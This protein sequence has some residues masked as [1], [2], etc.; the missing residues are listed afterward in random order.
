MSNTEAS[1]NRTDALVERLFMATIDTMEE[2]ASIHVGGRLGFYRAL[3]EDGPATPAELASRTAT[4]ERY[5]REW[6]EQQAVAGFLA[7]ENTEAEAGERRYSLPPEHRPVFVDELDLH[8]LVGFAQ[9][10]IGMLRPIDALLDAYRSGGGVPYEAY[11]PDLVAGIAA[12]N[13]PQFHNLLAGWFGEIQEVDARLRVE[14]AARV[15]DVGCGVGWSSIAIAHAYPNAIVDAIDIDTESV[16]AARSNVAAAGLTERVHP[17]THDASRSDLGG[18]YDLITVFEALHDMNHPVD[19]LR[20]FRA[21][22]TDG[23]CVVIADERVAD[24]FTAPGDEIER[25][26]YGFSILHC[27]PVANLDED[28]AATGTVI[29]SDT[30]RA[31]ATE[32]GFGRVDIL[33]IDHDL[34]RFYLLAD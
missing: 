21:S 17:R 14:P 24:R 1:G 9:C 28:S 15:A 19:A 32:A 13:R 6:L 29:R 10:A 20:S 30:V 22:L 4:A 18:R 26:D 2:V 7:V 8:Y 16:E 27:V 34:W 23:G 31:Y 33:P 11:G 12:G 25:L 5:V 3:A